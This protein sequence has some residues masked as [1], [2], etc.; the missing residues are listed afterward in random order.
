MFMTHEGIHG[1]WSAEDEGLRVKLE[2][3]I[4]GLPEDEVAAG[5]AA[6]ACEAGFEVARSMTLTRRN[7]DSTTKATFAAVSGGSVIVAL[8]HLAQ[9]P[10]R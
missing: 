4:A 10:A 5:I 1:V 3:L 2:A 9:L 6:I 8:P 7:G